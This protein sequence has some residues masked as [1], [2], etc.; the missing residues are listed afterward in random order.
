MAIE[1]IGAAGST[2]V[3]R[4]AKEDLPATIKI[5]QSTGSNEVAT[6]QIAV[7]AGNQVFEDYV[8]SGTPVTATE[9][10]ENAT[11]LDSVGVYTV[12]KTGGTGDGVITMSTPGNL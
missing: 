9:G 4:V 8:R 2:K 1:L 11:T 7:D 3:F 10:V 6:L 5:G 12:N